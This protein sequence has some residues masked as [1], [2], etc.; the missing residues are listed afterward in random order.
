MTRDQPPHLEGSSGTIDST[1]APLYSDVVA[2]RPP[3]PHGALSPA[4]A[5]PHVQNVIVENIDNN[6]TPKREV[7]RSNDNEKLS[8]ERYSPSYESGLP[9]EKEDAQWTTV[10]RRQARSL[11]STNMSQ[12]APLR[13]EFGIL[14]RDQ[15]RAVDAAV[16]TMTKKERKILS[17]RQKKVAMH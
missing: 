2:L 4:S 6:V 9:Q 13:N 5:A 16:S 10:K 12:K 7:V 11:E 3:S 8:V 15:T 1:A 14:T 17:Q